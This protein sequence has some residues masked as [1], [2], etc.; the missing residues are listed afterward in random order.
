MFAALPLLSLILAAFS[1]TTGN[2]AITT[3]SALS[4]AIRE[5]RPLPL[6]YD[7]VADVT[8]VSTN[9]ADETMTLALTDA[10]GSCRF[11]S[12]GQRFFKTFPRS[13]ARAHCTGFVERNAHGRLFP[14][15]TSYE[16][17]GF[18]TPRSPVMLTRAELFDG[19]H[20][21]V[22]CSFEGTL[23]DAVIDET[24]PYWIYFTI[25]NNEG[26][27]FASV[28]ISDTGD[29]ARMEKRI[30]NTVVVNG[31]C[32]PYDHSPRIQ[33]GRIFKIAAIDQIR[34]PKDDMDSAILPPAIEGIRLSQPSDIATLG[35]HRA[36]GWVVAV[37]RDNHALV[38]TEGNNV[39]GLEFAGGVQLPSYGQ[40]I[41]A[42]GL[43]DTDLFRINLFNATWRPDGSERLVEEHPQK[44]SAKYLTRDKK[45]KR[46]V[47][48]EHYG[49]AISI[50][51][52]VRSLSRDFGENKIYIESDGCLVS[53]D[54]S[55][56]PSAFESVSVGCTV[57]PPPNW[58]SAV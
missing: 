8:Y 35:R 42:T 24:N 43:P 21:F 22:F 40:K 41:E 52:I 7:I 45:G 3:I 5:E 44:V 51:G 57:S 30:G 11:H 14:V 29:L 39:I 37:W 32:V 50:V 12:R 19:Q 23:R 54:A 6:R 27:I 31:I 26:R 2:E 38:R 16:E 10:T 36:M 53:V 15:L 56:T 18:S 47:N 17:T 34:F 25:C 48:C 49:H 58:N 1:L 9:I 55:V 46:R 28:P 13:G 4:E 20:D 33:I